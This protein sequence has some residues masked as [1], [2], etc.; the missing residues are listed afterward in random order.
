MAEDESLCF[1]LDCCPEGTDVPDIITSE[2]ILIE[3]NVPDNILLTES[4]LPLFS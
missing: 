4:D 1:E 2:P 3:A